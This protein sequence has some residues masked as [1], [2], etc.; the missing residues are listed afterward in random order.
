VIFPFSSLAHSKIQENQSAPVYLNEKF[1]NMKKYDP[2][3][4]YFT[5][6][7]ICTCTELARTFNSRQ[8]GTGK[9]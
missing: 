4:A 2:G 6:K 1:I 7:S 5:L 8:P 3:F 9:I